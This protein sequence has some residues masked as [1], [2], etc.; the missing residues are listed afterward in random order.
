MRDK[1]SEVLQEAIDHSWHVAM[2]QERGVNPDEEPPRL[3]ASHYAD[4][5]IAAITDGAP[6]V[7]VSSGGI[8][9]TGEIEYPVMSAPWMEH[10]VRTEFPG[11]NHGTY[12][13]IRKDT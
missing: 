11:R 13:L 1:I 10:D 7:D 6:T 9:E 4:R 2:Y 5:I 3:E 12:Y 8:H